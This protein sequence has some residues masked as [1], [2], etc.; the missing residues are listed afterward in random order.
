MGNPME[1][2]SARN[3]QR[4]VIE[5]EDAFETE[6]LFRP[7]SSPSF[8]EGASPNK[9]GPEQDA[10]WSTSVDALFL[11]PGSGPSARRNSSAGTTSGNV[12]KSSFPTSTTVS[13]PKGWKLESEYYPYYS[14]Y[15]AQPNPKTTQALIQKLSP[16][17]TKAVKTYGGD[18]NDPVLRAKAK[19]LAI[20]ALNKYDPKKAKLSSYL[21][22]HLQAL[23]R[24]SAKRNM[25]VSIP[26]RLG[27][28]RQLL[29]RKEQELEDELGREPT[30]EELADA[31]G[32]SIKRIQKI[33][34][35]PS[36]VSES[37]LLNVNTEDEESVYDPEVVDLRD[38]GKLA[39]R[40]V[41]YNS[42]DPRDKLIME[43]TLGMNGKK[44]LDGKQLARRLGVSEA[45]ISQRKQKIQEMLNDPKSLE[46]L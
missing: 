35:L 42:L 10:P 39:W 30:D 45:Y 9:F 37:T 40:Q 33:R 14:E 4:S 36:V 13:S 11:S 27:M 41:V 32:I 23:R 7:S 8:E 18:V 24:Y 5:H 44:I 6:D 3:S 22:V 28:E 31:L 1:R 21:L 20:E 16:V 12:G 46:F 26:E 17:I 25:I 19:V 38:S 43:H 34:M 15:L 2:R 29:Y